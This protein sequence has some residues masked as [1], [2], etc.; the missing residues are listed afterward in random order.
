MD[1]TKPPRKRATKLKEYLE[2]RS[3]ERNVDCRIQLE[4]DGSTRENWMET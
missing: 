4:K 3:A 1:S 2:Q